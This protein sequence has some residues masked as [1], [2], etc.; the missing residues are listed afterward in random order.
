MQWP[1]SCNLACSVQVQERKRISYEHR[2]LHVSLLLLLAKA[3][4]FVL[5]WWLPRIFLSS[6]NWQ[7]GQKGLPLFRLTNYIML[8]HSST[9][10]APCPGSTTNECSKVYCHTIEI[11]KWN[12]VNS[13]KWPTLRC[14]LVA[15][16]TFNVFSPAHL[17][18][19]C[20]AMPLLLFSPFL[21]S[22]CQLP[23]HLVLRAVFVS[24]LPTRS[25]ILCYKVLT[26]FLEHF[27]RALRF[28][29]RDLT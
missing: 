24:R 21:S 29:S 12:I 19:N 28:S 15:L 26:V 7:R 18:T 13:I 6:G 22:S 10:I 2:D 3:H 27:S 23:Y 1:Y 17:L 5:R 16:I 9:E 8:R 14:K 4:S 25:C 20:T 11:R